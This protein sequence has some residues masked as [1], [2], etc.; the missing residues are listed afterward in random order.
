[1]TLQEVTKE[2]L[3]RV[4]CF[5]RP[6]TDQFQLQNKFQTIRLR[7]LALVECVVNMNMK[8]RMQCW[9]Q[10]ST[11]DRSLIPTRIRFC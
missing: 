8:F 10:G 2:Y 4:T 7:A 11:I 9:R 3:E 5:P 6:L 1:M